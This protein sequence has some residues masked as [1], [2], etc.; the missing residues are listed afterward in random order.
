MLCLSICSSRTPSLLLF[1]LYSAFKIWT[2][3][4]PQPV[5][6]RTRS[7]EQSSVCMCAW[8]CVCFDMCNF[9]A[10]VSVFMSIT[11]CDQINNY[12]MELL[13]RLNS[14][15]SRVCNIVSAKWFRG[16]QISIRSF[17]IISSLFLWKLGLII[18]HSHST[19]QRF[20]SDL[21]SF[22]YV[23]TEET[24]QYK[25]YTFHLNKDLGSDCATIQ[26]ICRET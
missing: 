17:C 20:D 25:M 26:K 23:C 2:L 22:L 5:R 1:S 16:T 21:T 4:L 10:K 13:F 18:P 24:T 19:D 6:H 9:S 8:P 12:L 7:L 15:Y 14:L 3:I 11:V